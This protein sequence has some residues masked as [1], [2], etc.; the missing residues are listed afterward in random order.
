[1]SAAFLL[2]G[3]AAPALTKKIKT[4]TRKIQKILKKVWVVNN[5]MREVCC[6]FQCI[7]R[8]HVVLINR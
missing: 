1:M 5:L 8:V 6:K 2:P 7:V 4:N 3:S